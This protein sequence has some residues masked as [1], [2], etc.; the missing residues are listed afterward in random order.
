[1]IK[2]GE[3]PVKSPT[4]NLNLNGLTKEPAEVFHKMIENEKGPQL[5]PR[6]LKLFFMLM[7]FI[8]ILVNC[9]HGCIPAATINIR[10]MLDGDNMKLGT[11]GSVVYIG[12]LIGSFTAPPTFH[13]LSAKLIISICLMGNAVFLL[14]FSLVKH[15]WILCFSR[16]FVGFFEVFLC[17][18]FPVWVDVFAHDKSKTI[19]LTIL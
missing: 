13:N 15:F 3:S 4:N 9:E 14:I 1:M 11:L 12:L 10:E 6:I 7:V 18:Y 5:N 2:K 8:N 19:W 17:I 16:L